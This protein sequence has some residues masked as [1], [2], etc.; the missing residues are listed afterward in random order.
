M[1]H[2]NY[3]CPIFPHF[4]INS[5]R[6]VLDRGGPAWARRWRTP[7][8]ALWGKKVWFKHQNCDLTTKI[9]NLTTQ[10]LDLAIKSARTEGDLP[11]KYPLW[12]WLYT[13]SEPFFSFP[14]FLPAMSDTHM[15]HH[16]WSAVGRWYSSGSWR[17]WN[18]HAG[19]CIPIAASIHIMCNVRICVDWKHLLLHQQRRQTWLQRAF[20]P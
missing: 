15:L 7:A 14:V 2:I 19:G 3:L 10:K 11:K 16:L 17:V 18:C 1:V 6:S 4:F 20:R 12:W 13:Y 5:C 8:R 9:Q